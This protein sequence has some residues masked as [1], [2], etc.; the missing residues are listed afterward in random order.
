M[1]CGV[2]NPHG[3]HERDYWHL[4][5]KAAKRLARFDVSQCDAWIWPRLSRW[6]AENTRSEAERAIFR[7]PEEVIL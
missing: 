1:R 5:R 6:R 2:W 4:S 3:P 7:S